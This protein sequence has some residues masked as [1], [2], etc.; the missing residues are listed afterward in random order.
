MFLLVAPTAFLDGSAAFYRPLEAAGHL[1]EDNSTAV[2]VLL[3]DYA[4]SAGA[5][6]LDGTAPAYY[7][8]RGVGDGANK[9]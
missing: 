1:N 3:S 7:Y 8:R 9:W 2:K 5:K 4:V 6:C